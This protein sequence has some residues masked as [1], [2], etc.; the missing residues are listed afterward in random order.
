MASSK[1]ADRLRQAIA[2]LTADSRHAVRLGDL[3]RN[4][5]AQHG[6]TT[7]GQF[8]DALR[9]LAARGA[10]RLSPYTGAMYQLQDPECC[11]IL[12]REIMGYVSR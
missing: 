6:P 12:G 4:I 5:Q 9:D 7:L 11:L 3:W 2:D 10:I 8:H 1:P